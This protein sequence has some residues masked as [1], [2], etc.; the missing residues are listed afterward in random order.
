MAI[1]AV[2]E[3]PGMNADHFDRILAALKEAGQADPDGRLF[4]VAAPTDDG[5][6]VVDVW[7]S[8]EKLGAFAGVLMPI[9]AGVGVTPPQP[10]IA[11]VHYM[12]PQ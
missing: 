4:H 2:F 12:S 5:W 7:E 8:E 1:A 10:R 6:L 9:I 11:P 3:V